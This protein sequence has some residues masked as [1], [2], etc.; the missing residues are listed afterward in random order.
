MGQGG[1][2]VGGGGVAEGGVASFGSGRLVSHVLAGARSVSPRD[3]F[4]PLTR[5]LWVSARGC[6]W[7]TA[8]R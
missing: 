2:C 4:F 6:G 7:G 1:G 8:G 3:R 5:R